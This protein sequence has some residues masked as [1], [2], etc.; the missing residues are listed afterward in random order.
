MTDQP[1]LR[2]GKRHF[3]YRSVAARQHIAHARDAIAALQ[4]SG[5]LDRWLR[6]AGRVEGKK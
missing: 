4:I 2:A 6:F 3:V 5:H 1:I